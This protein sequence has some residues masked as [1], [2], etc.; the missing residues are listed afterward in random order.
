VD[1]NIK[2]IRSNDPENIIH[3]VKSVYDTLDTILS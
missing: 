3:H 2:F 1:G